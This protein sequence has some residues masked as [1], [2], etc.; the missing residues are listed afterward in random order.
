[1]T[2]MHEPPKDLTAAV[3]AARAALQ[4]DD[5]ARARDLLGAV[6]SAGQANAT[7]FLLL[8][9]AHARLGDEA[10]RASAIDEALAR[11]PRNPRALIFKADHLALAGD[12]RA[13][14]SFYVAARTQASRLTSI[15]ADLQDDLQRAHA[16]S[17]RMMRE[18]EDFL[19]ARLDGEG[20]G[21]AA[22]PR[23]FARSVDILFG[24]KQAYQQQPRYLYY[25][26]LPPIQFYPREQFPWLDAVEAATQ[27]VRAELDAVLAQP[28]SFGPYLTADPNRPKRAQMG[29]LGNPNWGAYFLWKDGAQQAGAARCPRTMAALR[30]A[31]LTQIPNRA[32]AILFSKL[33]ARTQIPPHTGMIN[34]RLICHLPLRVPEGCGFRVGDEVRSW[35]EGE[36]WVF[37]DTIEHEAWNRSGIDRYILLFD[38]WRPELADEERA[39][40][41]AL[42]RAIDAFGGGGAAWDA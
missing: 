36:A 19:R 15:P 12:L 7:A 4:R 27:D 38:I 34:A 31:P 39:G 17:E 9:Q 16:V 32:P 29:L 24:R 42:C 41:A 10:G 30:E 14:L 26:E 1:M 35:V 3:E 37:D 20:F 13:A 6:V 23:R 33:A 25:P 2:K 18:F 28:D 8:A 21:S 11:E 5:A 40:I 22:M